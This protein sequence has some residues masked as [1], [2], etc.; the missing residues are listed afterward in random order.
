M[1]KKRPRHANIKIPSDERIVGYLAGLMDG[2][3]YIGIDRV[4]TRT[5]KNWSHHIRL[6]I[7]NTDPR[8]M[9]FLTETIGGRAQIR[10][11]G[12]PHHAQ[13]WNWCLFSNN[14]YLFLKTIRP[15]LVLKGEQADIVTTFF[16]LTTANAALN[17]TN[18]LTQEFIQQREEMHAKLRVLNQRG[19]KIVGEE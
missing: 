1:R 10:Q 15:F 5:S 4:F 17:G 11:R 9:K 19:L 7:T 16:E 2:E 12:K 8:L 6:A 14:A 13:G 3:G 18:P